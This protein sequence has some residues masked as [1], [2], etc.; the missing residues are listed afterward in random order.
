[1]ALKIKPID[2]ASLCQFSGAGVAICTEKMEH[3]RNVVTVTQA[4]A[5]G[6]RRL[7]SS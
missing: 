5:Y 3:Q 7:Q 6:S 1:V 4:E 2:I